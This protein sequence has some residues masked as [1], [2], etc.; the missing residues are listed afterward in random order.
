MEPKKIKY[1]TDKQMPEEKQE[2]TV[3]DQEPET[4]Q[5]SS[6]TLFMK[7]GIIVFS[8]SGNTLSVGEKLRDTLVSQGNTV[9]LERVTAEKDDPGPSDKIVL[10]SMPLITNYD[11]IIFGAPVQA[12]SLSPIMSAYLNQLPK[13]DGKKIACFVTEQFPKPW[14]GGNQALKKMGRIITQNGGKVTE[15]GVVNW[16]NKAREDQIAAILERFKKLI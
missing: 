3:I 14:M 9:Q 5:I 15:T 10:T 11:I 13:L 12:F 1:L 6:F 2:I 16:S 4:K 7:V 8:H